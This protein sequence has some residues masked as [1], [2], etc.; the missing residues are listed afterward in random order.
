M[1]DLR[2]SPIIRSGIKLPHRLPGPKYP[3]PTDCS[4]CS[5][6]PERDKHDEYVCGGCLNLYNDI[7]DKNLKKWISWSILLR[8]KLLQSL[9][10]SLL[11]IK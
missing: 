2:L 10:K 9:L 8:K 5:E 3:N 7:Y 1:E 6:E 11:L 4:L